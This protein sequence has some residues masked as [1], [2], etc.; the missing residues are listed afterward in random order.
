M[1]TSR[2]KS[3]NPKGAQAGLAE[4]RV[5]L[6]G[7]A[8]VAI[9]RVG[10]SV[11]WRKPRKGQAG[12]SVMFPPETLLV[13]L[14]AE[15]EARYRLPDEMDRQWIRL[16][17]GTLLL[18]Y[19]RLGSV[20]LTVP[21]L[22]D[23]YSL[24]SEIEFF[25]H[26][27]FEYQQAVRR[28]RSKPGSDPLTVMHRQ[29]LQSVRRAAALLPYDRQLRVAER[30]VAG[31][32]EGTVERA[33]WRVVRAAYA[34]ST[35][36]EDPLA[37]LRS[38]PQDLSAEPALAQDW[39]RARLLLEC[40][41]RELEGSV[42]R[43]LYAE[44]AQTVRALAWSPDGTRLASAGDGG[45]VH[46]CDANAAAQ[47]VIGGWYNDVVGL[48]WSPDGRVSSL[49]SHGCT[50][51]WEVNA[52]SLLQNLTLD[53]QVKAFSWSPDGSKLAIAGGREQMLLCFV[54]LAEGKAIFDAGVYGDP[55][56][57]VWS[58][59]WSS[60]GTRIAG[61]RGTDGVTIWE[62]A[63][64]DRRPYHL[65]L[66]WRAYAAA[67][68]PAGDL[69]ALAG[70]KGAVQLWDASAGVQRGSCPGHAAA[71]LELAWSPDGTYLAST[72]ADATLRVWHAGTGAQLLCHAGSRLFGKPLWSPSS[73][74]VA[75]PGEDGT[76]HIATRDGQSWQVADVYLGH[77]GCWF[78]GGALA[79]SPVGARLASAA[80][81]PR[82][83]AG[84]FAVHVWSPHGSPGTPLSTPAGP[85]ASRDT[86]AY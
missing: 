35:G 48:C 53:L 73:T 4:R 68:A 62:P 27:W 76:V 61:A 13:T 9:E 38:L 59:S 54:D 70:E 52:G 37:S 31:T 43:L 74:A 42:P 5:Q 15:E 57:Q 66:P 25:Q 77:L 28:G 12:Q 78:A 20:F 17:D 80:R 21:G 39:P 11:E 36:Q 29:L 19:S 22:I 33:V 83:D 72:A 32:L 24:E 6:G 47:Q 82:I 10:G 16:P 14:S 18:R 34:R 46:I 1:N 79:W 26:R 49:S 23:D 75:C 63:A 7:T 51:T 41:V 71:V 85:P 44:H 64:P 69:L 8:Q 2:R 56:M 65:L 58:L 55:L 86:L 67:F 30:G 50:Q 81:E 60:D 45:Q 84:N 3:K 40:A